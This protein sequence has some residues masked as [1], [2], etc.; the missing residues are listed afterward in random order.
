MRLVG[1]LSIVL[2][3]A[4]CGGGSSGPR[5][6]QDTVAVLTIRSTGI[7]T[8]TGGS[9]I[10]SVPNP[11]FVQFT[12]A[13][14]VSHTIVASNANTI[15]DCNP[16]GAGSIAPGTSTGMIQLSNTNGT[17]E[18]CTFSDSTNAAISGTVTI[19]PGQTGGNG[20]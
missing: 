3:L 14:T 18:S 8:Q 6:T 1:S 20:Y 11:G 9:A 12:N 2:A 16:L 13:D 5:T 19:L 7:T 4:A 10:F 17:N 15:P